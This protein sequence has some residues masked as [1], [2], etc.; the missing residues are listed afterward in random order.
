[1]KATRVNAYMIRNSQIGLAI[2]AFTALTLHWSSPQTALAEKADREK[3]L[4]IE[5]DRG[6]MDEKTG[7]ARF[8]GNV[9]LSQGTLIIRADELETHQENGNFS[10]GIAKGK[11]A[12][13]KQKREGFD[14]FIEGEADR[15]E[16]S[17]SSEIL[18][19]FTDAKLWRNGDIVEGDFITYNAVSEIF[20]ARGGSNESKQSNNK[21]RVRAVIMPKKE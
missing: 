4:N 17:S 12:Y 8:F 18:K 1:M 14:E 3:P 9:I 21:N 11:P 13:F 6:E 2:L 19:M 5:A 10:L 7:I 20:E 15:I 16:Y